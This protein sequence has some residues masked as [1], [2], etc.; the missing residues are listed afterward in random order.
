MSHFWGIFRAIK[1]Q[2]YQQS[3][4]HCGNCKTCEFGDFFLEGTVVL[5]PT[6]HELNSFFDLLCLFSAV[7]I[8]PIRSNS[9]NKNSSF[10]CNFHVRIEKQIFSVIYEKILPS[11]RFSFMGFIIKPVIQLRM[12]VFELLIDMPH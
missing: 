6:K 2:P 11:T 3:A 10:S 8:I 9:S 5:C 7:K 4:S 1:S 12:K